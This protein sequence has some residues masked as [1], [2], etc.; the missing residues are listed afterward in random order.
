MFDVVTI[1]FA[2]AGGGGIISEI[3]SQV[4]TGGTDAPAGSF[5]FNNYHYLELAFMI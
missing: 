2:S 5:L 3:K 4:E 1:T